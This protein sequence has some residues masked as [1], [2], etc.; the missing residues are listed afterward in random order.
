M[1]KYQLVVA[2]S[3]WSLWVQGVIK[4]LFMFTSPAF[5]SVYKAL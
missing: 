5:A 4:P 2:S 1:G 3:S